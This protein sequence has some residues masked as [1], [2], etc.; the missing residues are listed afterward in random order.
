MTDCKIIDFH[1]HILP[2]VDHGST[3]LEISM[4]QMSYAKAAD[5]NTVVAT[6]HFYPH[7]HEVDLFLEVRAEAYNHLVKEIEDKGIKIEVILAAEVLLCPGIERLPRLDELCVNGT[8]NIL[9]EL[10]FSDFRDEYIDA[11]DNLISA[12]YNVILAHA[13]RYELAIIE[14]MISVGAKLQLNADSITAL[15]RKPWIFDWVNRGL[16]YALG[17]DIHML[18]KGAYKKFK[19]AL[20]KLGVNAQ[21]IMEKSFDLINDK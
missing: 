8:K 20:K 3:S 12:G 14:Q 21:K 11:V 17:S 15:V 6:S 18:D 2:E 13:D 9:I 10:P 5:V 4:K 16:V 7:K 1:S 19:S